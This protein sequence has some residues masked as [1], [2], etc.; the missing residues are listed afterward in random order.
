MRANPTAA[1]RGSAGTLP[2]RKMTT[3]WVPALSTCSAPDWGSQ[4]ARSPR[5]EA[6]LPPPQPRVRPDGVDDGA[7]R[8]V[9]GDGR[10]RAHLHAQV[11]V[12]LDG[13]EGLTGERR[14]RYQRGGPPGQDAEPVVREERRA[15]P[16]RDR[17]PGRAERRHGTGQALEQPDQTRPVP[18]D[19]I[20]RGD[21]QER[22]RRRT[23]TGLM[24]PGDG[25]HRIG[26]QRC[27]DERDGTGAG[28]NLTPAGALPHRANIWPSPAI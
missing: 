20:E 2:P 22:Q 27:G 6:G 5:P 17:R 12:A 3:S 18:G 9:C 28:E 25:V 7:D 8:L 10:G 13:V 21:R 14:Q 24:Y 23:D 26:G 16:D 4:Y 15:E 19:D 1:P 11:A